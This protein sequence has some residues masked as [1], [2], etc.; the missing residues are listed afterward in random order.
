MLSIHL[1]LMAHHGLCS[2]GMPEC[3]PFG[4]LPLCCWVTLYAQTSE[5]SALTVTWL[6]STAPKSHTYVHH[7]HLYPTPLL[8]LHTSSLTSTPPL[9]PPPTPLQLHFLPSHFLPS[10]LLPSH[11]HPSPPTSTPPLLPSPLP[12]HL[13]PSTP[14]STPPLPPPPISHPSCLN[15]SP[16]TSTPPFL[17]PPLPPASTLPSPH[18]AQHTI[19]DNHEWI[20][21]QTGVRCFGDASTLPL[22]DYSSDQAHLTGLWA[23]DSSAHNTEHTNGTVCLLLPHTH[24]IH[25][26]VRHHSQSHCL[27]RPASLPSELFLSLY[28]CANVR[29]KFNQ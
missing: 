11:L 18:V 19:E 6:R 27:D 4:S 26:V 24:N 8:H 3:S 10:H 9:S 17:P 14:A 5:E 28:V 12:S 2:T 7:H 21:T 23:Q 29:S 20:Q 15:P 1:S 16:P 13:H 25:T 22:Q